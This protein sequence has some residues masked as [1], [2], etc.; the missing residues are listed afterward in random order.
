MDV[1]RF[2]TMN[3]ERPTCWDKGVILHELVHTIGFYHEHQRPDRDQFINVLLQNVQAGIIDTVYKH[4]LRTHHR[5]V[6]CAKLRQ[7]N[8]FTYEFDRY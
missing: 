5:F 3:L 1:R 7:Y 6:T 2:Q 8:I 4:G